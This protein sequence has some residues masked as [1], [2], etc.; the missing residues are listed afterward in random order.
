M[1]FLDIFLCGRISSGF[2][3]LPSE[4]QEE[5][6][7]EVVQNTYLKNDLFLI[8]DLVYIAMSLLFLHR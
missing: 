2:P 5:V 3:E 8:P 6:K 7:V 1:R 4:L